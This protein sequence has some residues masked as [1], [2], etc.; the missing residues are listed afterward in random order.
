M[1]HLVRERQPGRGEH[2]LHAGGPEAELALSLAK[3]VPLHLALRPYKLV[4]RPGE[5]KIIPMDH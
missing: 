5:R 4:R 1:S 3:E 2:R